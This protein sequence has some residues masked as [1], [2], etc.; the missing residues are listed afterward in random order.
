MLSYPAL[1]AG[2]EFVYQALADRKIHGYLHAFLDRDV[3]PLLHAPAGM[4]LGDYRDTILR[5]FSNP[6]VRDQLARIASD[7]AAKIQIFLGL[8][9]ARTCWRAAGDH[10][11]LAFLFAA[12]GR[13]LDGRDDRGT[14]FEPI[15]PHLTPADHTMADRGRSGSSPGTSPT[16][17]AWGW[18]RRRNFEPACRT[19]GSGSR[20]RVCSQR[21]RL[22]R[23]REA[24][25]CTSK[26]MI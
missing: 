5:R 13:Y 7:G 2:Y 20:L 1:L 16:S 25:P 12:F 19:T 8:Y 18:R 14:A 26:S 11:R 6:A 24:E 9:A 22:S 10:R 3:I 4:S 17:R 23:R 15:E 21:W